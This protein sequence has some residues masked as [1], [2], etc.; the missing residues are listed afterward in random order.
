MA[1]I[2]Q[3]AGGTVSCQ[4]T[5]AVQQL[6]RGL[7]PV[8]VLRNAAVGSRLWQEVWRQ[9]SSSVQLRT[10]KILVQGVG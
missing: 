3:I 4:R 7:S 8:E 9:P 1:Q 2:A 10:P 5:A 6:V